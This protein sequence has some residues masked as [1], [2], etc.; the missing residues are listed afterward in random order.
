MDSIT[1]KIAIRD[2]TPAFFTF[3]EG[4]NTKVRPTGIFVRT[5]ENPLNPPLRFI[6][7]FVVPEDFEQKI[8]LDYLDDV[9]TSPDQI[10]LLPIKRNPLLAYLWTIHRV[11]RVI[12]R[13]FSGLPRID[14]LKNDEPRK[15]S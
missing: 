5:N 9:Y 2:E 12:K 4:L 10:E 11:N 7:N 13:V 15:T 14:E 3:D 6:R 8:F 1:D